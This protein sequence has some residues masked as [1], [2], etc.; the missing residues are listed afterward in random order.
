MKKHALKEIFGFG[1]KQDVP[2]P[3]WATG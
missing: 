2:T 3:P 1:R